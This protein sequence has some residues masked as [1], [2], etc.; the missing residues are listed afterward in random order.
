[1]S[2][3]S[4]SEFFYFNYKGFDSL[5]L[6]TEDD[7]EYKFMYANVGANGA[8]CDA[9]VFNMSRFKR[10]FEE[11]TLHLPSS[12]PIEGDD[13]TLPYFTIGDEALIR[14]T[15]VDDEALTPTKSQS[16]GTSLQLPSHQARRVVEN[17]FGILASSRFRCMLGTLAL[18]P[19]V[20]K[21]AVHAAYCL[22][23]FLC[24]R[25]PTYCLAKADFE[26]PVT[27]EVTPGEGRENLNWL[28]WTTSYIP[29][30]H[31]T[32]RTSETP[33]WSFTTSL[34]ARLNGRTG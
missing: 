22:Y 21:A 13:H 25:S 27:H 1:M 3:P 17:V 28:D 33:S 8:T 31:R 7:S 26:D 10:A 16:E 6:L 15:V 32:P 19:R 9:Q 11:R 20:V 18:H 24:V 12:E 14:P 30:Q 2:A 4:H 5:V 34:W 29:V 23:N